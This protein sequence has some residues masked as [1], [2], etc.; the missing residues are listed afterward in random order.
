MIISP[1]FF[2]PEGGVMNFNVTTAYHVCAYSIAPLFL[3]VNRFYMYFTH[4][5][6]KLMI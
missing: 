5:F 6:K 2:I 4:F 1:K 3:Y